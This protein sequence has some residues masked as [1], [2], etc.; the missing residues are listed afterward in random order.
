MKINKNK[1]FTLLE[2]MVV[3]AIAAIMVAL[4]APSL[5][6]TYQNQQLEGGKDLFLRHLS[7]ARLEAMSRGERVALCSA[8]AAMDDCDLAANAAAATASARFWG[9][10]WIMFVDRNGNGAVDDGEVIIQ[11]GTTVARDVGVWQGNPVNGLI[12][13]VGYGPSGRGYTRTAAGISQNVRTRFCMVDRRFTVGVNERYFRE[14]SIDFLGRV[15]DRSRTGE[16]LGSSTAANG[17]QC[18]G[19]A[20]L[21]SQV[22]PGGISVCRKEAGL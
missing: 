13:Y 14:I 9:S 1:G 19:G 22:Q 21:C 6:R 7:Q 2:L 16:Q 12:G 8:N 4:A 3:V 5:S 11:K 10:G 20:N 15:R 18:V 17:P